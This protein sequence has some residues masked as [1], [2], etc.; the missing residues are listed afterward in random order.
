MLVW[1]IVPDAPP[2]GQPLDPSGDGLESPGRISGVRHFGMLMFLVS[3]AALFIPL[4]ILLVVIRVQAPQW[5][6]RG[7][8]PLPSNLLLSTV[9]LLGVSGVMEGALREVRRSRQAMARRFVAAAMILV[10]AFICSQVY[11]WT[12]FLGNDIPLDS[13]RV[14]GYFYVLTAVHA[15]HVIGG[16]VPL[17]TVWSHSIRGRYSPARHDGLRNCAIYWH[18]L[19][20]VWVVMLVALMLLL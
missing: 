9:L 6:P 3:L 14:A 4:L 8:P 1:P 13:W 2:D 5:P 18:F 19:D 15:L 16:T 17:V 12:I 20:G 11:A 10:A 7:L